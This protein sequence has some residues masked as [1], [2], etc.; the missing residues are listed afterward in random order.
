M[1]NDMWKTQIL[2][3]IDEA[4]DGT[5]GVYMDKGTNLVAELKALSG[6]QASTILPGAGNSV[7]NQIQHLLITVDAHEPQFVGG[8]YPDIDWGS[9]WG[10]VHLS[11]DQWQAMVN[12]YEA[13][14]AKFTSWISEPTVAEDE[15]YAAAAVMAAAHMAYHAGQI[16]HAAAYA[17]TK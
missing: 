17:A 11:D 4:Y 14:H 9:E 7:A 2:K 15:A 12:E 13:T 6:E 3:A 16:R 1:S 8:E 5:G 10:E